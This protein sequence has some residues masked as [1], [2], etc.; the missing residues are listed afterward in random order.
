MSS[1]KKR[2]LTKSRYK[3]ALECPVKL[4]YTG[5]KDYA[6]VKVEDPF[7]EALAQGGF[8]VE[9]L[10]R[11]EYLSWGFESGS[12]ALW[13]QQFRYAGVYIHHFM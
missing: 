9:E 7:L 13:Q 11:M 1:N 4:F 10:A 8:Q 12:C 2:Y 6:N 3:L 5:K